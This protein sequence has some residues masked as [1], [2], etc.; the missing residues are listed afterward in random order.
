MFWWIFFLKFS[1]VLRDGFSFGSEKNLFAICK[2]VEIGRLMAFLRIFQL[3]RRQ[4]FALRQ[5]MKLEIQS[6]HIENFRWLIEFPCFS[7]SFIVNIHRENFV[8][9][10]QSS[11]KDGWKINCIFFIS[12][13]LPVHC[14]KCIQSF[15]R[16][17]HSSR[18]VEIS[19]E[20]V[21]PTELFYFIKKLKP[22]YLLHSRKS[23]HNE[24]DS[25]LGCVMMWIHPF[26]AQIVWI[27]RVWWTMMRGLFEP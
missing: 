15:S 13:A 25:S 19:M 10:M 21:N 7:P 27:M 18:A 20:N 26:I 22:C 12:L 11:S 3:N 14:K 8:S 24:T 9:R 1:S 17:S 5:S 16:A 2:K 6:F 4:L 23:F